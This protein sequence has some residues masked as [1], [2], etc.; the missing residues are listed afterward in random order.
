MLQAYPE[1]AS[2]DLF[3]SGE[4]YA[5]VYIPMLAREILQDT[6]SSTAT[7]LKGMLIG[8]GC[9]GTD[10]LCG[11]Q[12]GHSGPWYHLQFFHGHGQVSDKLHDEI[13]ATCGVAQLKA[14]VTDP[15]CSAL[16]AQMDEA[17][18]GYFDYALYDECGPDTY[19]SP[20]PGMAG[21]YAHQRQRRYWSSAPPLKTRGSGRALAAAGGHGARG[22]GGQGRVGGALNDYPCGGVGAMLKWLNTSAVKQALHVPPTANYFLT[23]NGVGFNYNLTEKDLMPFYQQIIADKSMRVIVYNG[24]TD[25]G[26]VLRAVHGGRAVLTPHACSCLAAASTRLSRRTGPLHSALRRHSRG[27]RGRSTPSS[28]WA[29]TSRATPTTLIS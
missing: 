14:G 26:C 3:L 13:V 4:S 24:D 9:A 27:G 6:S 20:R 23:D 18:G 22:G 10:V 25:P 29:A 15:E 2:H 28:R 17:I 16:I 19:I 1:F 5:G 8:D 7:H 11:D 21:S 12:P